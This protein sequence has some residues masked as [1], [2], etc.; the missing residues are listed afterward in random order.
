MEVEK[1]AG[2]RNFPLRKTTTFDRITGGDS[3]FQQER[4]FQAFL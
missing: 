2:K 4:I 3:L 1:W